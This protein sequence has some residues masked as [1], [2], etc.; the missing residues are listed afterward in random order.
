[1][2]HVYGISTTIYANT[3]AAIAEG[4]MNLGRPF[5]GPTTPEN[6]KNSK[7]PKSPK[8]LKGF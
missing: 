6:S 1:M 5:K 8:K 3:N 4:L 2:S 7:S